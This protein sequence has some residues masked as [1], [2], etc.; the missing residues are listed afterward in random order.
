MA[1]PTKITVA[2][3]LKKSKDSDEFLVVRRP[4]EDSDLA[5]SWGFPAVTLEPGELPEQGAERVCREKLGCK[6]TASR[7]LGLMF[8]K[9]NNYDI[10]LMD[11]EMTLDEG[12]T[13]DVAKA[14]TT[15]TAYSS[16]I[17]TTDPMV[18]EPS[19][20]HGSCCASI[21]MTDRGLLDKDDWIKSLEGSDIV[22]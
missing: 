3:V 21:F 2:V 9:R 12:E 10:F 15:H 7:Y 22:G 13:A 16:Q 20:K 18:M 4:K 14:N 1:K 17:W 11:I 6:A 5:G 19:A 8:Q